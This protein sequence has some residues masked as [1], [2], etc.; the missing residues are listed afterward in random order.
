LWN[1]IRYRSLAG[2]GAGKTFSVTNWTGAGSLTGSG[3]DDTVIDSGTGSF[4]L[5]NT[6]LTAPRTTLR[7]GDITTAYLTTT[8]PSGG[9]AT[10]DYASAFTGVANLTAGGSGN[11]I[12]Y[13]SSG[14]KNT[15]SATGSGD[16]T[17]IGAGAGYKLTDSGSGMN[18]LIAGGAGGD[19]LT[20]NGNDI[21]ASGTTRYDA[22][23]AANIAALDAIIAEWTSSDSYSARIGKILAGVGALGAD[24]VDSST[25]SQDANADTLRDG[26]SQVQNNN[27]FVGWSND[28][29]KKN[30]SETKT[31]L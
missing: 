22:D 15:L 16:D 13:G 1:V 20:G 6:R 14:A 4:T 25:V 11:A 8:A 27:W 9:A 30:A 28:T 19:T 12:L 21:L 3:T 18:I 23:N 31:V 7:L 29:V 24:A 17:M 2:S 26:S 5:T 10:I